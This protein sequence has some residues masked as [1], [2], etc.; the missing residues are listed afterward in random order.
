M[1]KNSAT[2]VFLLFFLFIFPVFLLSLVI[3]RYYNLARSESYNRIFK[4]SEQYLLFLER[5]SDGSKFIDRVFSEAFESKTN[6]ILSRKILADRIRHLKS[7]YPDSLDFFVWNADGEVIDELTDQVGFIYLKKKLN[8]FFQSLRKLAENSFP[9]SPIVSRE[10]AREI[11]TYRQF[12]GPFVPAQKLADFF[13]PRPDAGCVKLHGKGRQAYAWYHSGAEFSILVLISYQA[14]HD[15]NY[16][17]DVCRDLSKR[18]SLV[19]FFLIDENTGAVFPESDAT[20]ARSLRLNLEKARR[21]VPAELLADERFHFIFRRLQTG[22]WAVAVVSKKAFFDSDRQTGTLVARLMAG[23]FLFTFCWQC[24][25]LVHKNPLNSIN[26]RLMAAFA[27]TVAIPVMIFATVGFE[28]VSQKEKRSEIDRRHELVQMLDGFDA[29]FSTYLKKVAESIDA[30]IDRE[31]GVQGQEKIEREKI[32]AL[33]AKLR[34]RLKTLAILAIDENGANLLPRSYSEMISDQ[35]MMKTITADLLEYLNKR[36]LTGV[37]PEVKITDTSILAYRFSNSAIRRFALASRQMLYYM[38]TLRDPAEKRYKFCFHILWDPGVLLREYLKEFSQQMDA[39]RL[40]FS[41]FMPDTGAVIGRRAKSPELTAFF[42]RAAQNG[43][44]IEK[45]RG[46]EVFY[47]AAAFRGRNLFNAVVGVATDYQTI[48]G[49]TS[50]LKLQLQQI[51]VLTLIFS[52]CLYKLLHSQIIFPLGILAGGVEMVR[53]GNYSQ[54]IDLRL[55]NEFGALADSINHTLENLQEFE[56]AKT[57]QEALL[58]ENLPELPGIGIFAG[59]LPMQKL[60][61]DYYDYY[62]D[63][64]GNLRLLIADIAGHGVQAAL[65]MAMARSVMLLGKNEKLTCSEIM[66]R[67]HQTFTQL[68]QANIRTMATCQLLQI[69]QSSGKIS[70]FNA[71]HCSPALINRLT[72]NITFPD[73]RSFPLGYGVKRDFAALEIDFPTDHFMVLYTDGILESKNSSEVILG[74]KV[75]S[76]W[77]LECLDEDPETFFRNIMGRYNDWRAFQDDDISL[78]ILKR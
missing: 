5:F 13:I 75:F 76:A 62:I 16:L 63:E 67:L 42:D 24:Y 60:G 33:A 32:Q 18:S 23:V 66:Q 10:L 17:Q 50:A 36:N 22:R 54:R 68:R 41:M 20:L 25:L 21:I 51:L 40:A 27:Y 59:T 37:L 1:R 74:P 39:G 52:L 69:P 12:L 78:V 55:K 64:H 45:L 9:A 4:K 56:I 35:S 53:S 26:S 61:G 70:L 8:V 2:K 30:E 31:I 49:E 15:E 34:N 7:R 38:R 43:I 47:L 6:G 44:H 3:H 57:V 77:L 65:M 72:R 19:D 46:N 58:P 71:G 28:Y 73:C 29:G 48:A 11:R 14:V